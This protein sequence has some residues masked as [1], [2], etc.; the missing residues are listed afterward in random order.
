MPAEKLYNDPV[1][2]IPASNATVDSINSF[3][4]ISRANADVINNSPAAIG[5][6]KTALDGVAEELRNESTRFSNATEPRCSAI[7]GAAEDATR[8]SEDGAGSC[9]SI[10]PTI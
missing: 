9:R 10:D 8:V 7:R 6:F 3:N 4:G 1:K 2:T 5:E